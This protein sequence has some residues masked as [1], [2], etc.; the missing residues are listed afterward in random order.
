MRL[1]PSSS[2]KKNKQP[3][4]QQDDRLWS[5]LGNRRET[6][7]S[8]GRSCETVSY[9]NKNTAPGKCVM[10]EAK[11]S[12]IHVLADFVPDSA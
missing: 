8:K 4:D 12:N 5:I 11:L 9:K 6:G 10:I 3:E 1:L 2:N 7:K